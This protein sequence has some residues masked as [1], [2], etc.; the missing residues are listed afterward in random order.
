M[1][2]SIEFAG[3][4]PPDLN[5]EVMKTFLNCSVAIFAQNVG[6]KYFELQTQPQ[7]YPWRDIL[8]TNASMYYQLRNMW[9]PEASKPITNKEFQSYGSAT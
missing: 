1:C 4:A 3:P 5:T 9:T 2:D 8:T 7:K 6:A